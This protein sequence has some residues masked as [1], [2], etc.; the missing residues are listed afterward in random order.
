[1]NLIF[2]L[3]KFYLNNFLLWMGKREDLTLFYLN[4]IKI[5]S[6]LWV[7]ERERERERK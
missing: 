2:S 3:S 5:I 1:M 7:G 4:S 6:L